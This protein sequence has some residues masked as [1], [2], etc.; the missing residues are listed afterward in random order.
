MNNLFS[1][2][3][4]MFR[5]LQLQALISKWSKVKEGKAYQTEINQST[6]FKLLGTLN[7]GINFFGAMIFLK[8]VSP[9]TN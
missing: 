6:Y 8:L 2:F 5:N 1:D 3:S 9:Q 7:K 4:I